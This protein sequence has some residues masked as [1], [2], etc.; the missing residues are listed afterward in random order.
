MIF[1]HPKNALF[2]TLGLL[3]LTLGALGAFLPIL[4]TT[5]F[6]LLAAYCFS[7]G[8]PKL[9]AW[10][11]STKLFGPLI[12]NWEQYGVV[13]VRAKILATVM[14][15]ILFSYTLIYVEV[16]LW[17]K[18][19]VTLSGLGVLLFLWTRPSSPTQT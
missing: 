10:L 13:G 7:K 4:P 8:S 12:Y 5:P 14:I 3:C 18:V 6:A 15:V 17:I 19:I 2:I 1:K 16:A 11:L 9:H